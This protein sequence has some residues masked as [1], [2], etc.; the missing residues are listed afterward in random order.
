MSNI[1]FLFG[2]FTASTVVIKIAVLR[3][4]WEFSHQTLAIWLFFIHIKIIKVC[5]NSHPDFGLF[6]VSHLKLGLVSKS[7]Q[8]H[9]SKTGF[10]VLRPRWEFS[11]QTLTIWL[12]F[13]HIKII[14]VCRTSHT[15]FG[16]FEVSHIKLG[17]VSKSRKTDFSKNRICRVKTSKRVF[18]SDSHNLTIFHT[19]QNYKS[20]SNFTSG[21][22]TF[23][24][25]GL[26]IRRPDLCQS[27]E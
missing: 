25:L 14:K 24:S 11:H 5:R 12:F 20:V 18:T 1:F 9:F 2:L 23:W 19:Y 4:R 16:L 3:P 10:A 17:L 15:D 27:L 21:F 8:T 6:E 13:I 22:R 26:Q 7:R